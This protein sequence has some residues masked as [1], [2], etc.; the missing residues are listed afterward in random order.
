MNKIGM[1]IK[2]LRLEAGYT[3]AKLAEQLN[4]T[5]DS[6]SL[7]ECDKRLPDVEYVVRMA[8]IFDVSTDYLLGVSEDFTKR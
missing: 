2:E 4:V 5:Q 8:E 7:W 3:Q 6:I 1:I